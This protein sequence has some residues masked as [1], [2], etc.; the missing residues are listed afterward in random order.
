MNRSAEHPLGTNRWIPQRAERVIDAPIARSWLLERSVQ[1]TG[2][3]GSQWTNEPTRPVIA[4]G[5]DDQIL[6]LLEEINDVK[7]QGDRIFIMRHA[8]GHATE[9]A[10]AIEA[11]I[12]AEFGA[13]HYVL[14]E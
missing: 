6:A 11:A 2:A 10:G 13:A 8:G 12:P 7:S 5:T 3:G 14:P 1:K 9:G 4:G